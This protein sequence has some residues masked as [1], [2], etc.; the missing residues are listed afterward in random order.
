MGGP[1]PPTRPTEYVGLIDNDG[2]FGRR[3][4][5][6]RLPVTFVTVMLISAC[7]TA[8]A[9]IDL[10][11]A[12]CKGQSINSFESRFP[13]IVKRLV[14][15]AAMLGPFVELWQAGSRPALPKRPERVIIYAL[16][17]LPLVIG[18]EEG[19]CIIAYLTVD[20]SFLWR[21]LRPRLGW[22]V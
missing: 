4:V 17:D 1:T 18:Y 19:H 22:K 13:A 7:T 21:W 15:D 3:L 5:L 9:E 16:P 20:S 6:K 10:E 2:P 14:V 11:E 8:A 12:A